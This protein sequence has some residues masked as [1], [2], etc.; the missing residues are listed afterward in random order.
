M[1]FIETWLP[2]YQKVVNTA[3][4][5]FFDTRYGP[6][7][8]I[9]STF[10]EALRYA[11]EWGGKRLRPILTL[12][13][14]EHF[15]QGKGKSIDEQAIL[16]SIGVECVHCFTLVHDDLPCMDNDELRRGKPTVWKAHGETM[17]VLVG[18]T[19][20]TMGFELL[21]RTGN[22]MVVGEIARALGDLG[23]ARGQIRDT[24]L[25]HD[26]LTLD[27]LLRL[28]DEKTG[29]F[30]ASCLVIGAQLGGANE[31]ETDT[32]RKFGFLLGRAFQIQDDILDYEGDASMVGKKVGKDAEIG[33][34]MV[35]LIR[36]DATKKILWDLEQEMLFIA[37][38]FNNAKFRDIVQYVVR[39]EK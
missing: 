22:A 14:Y 25:R 31:T 6:S 19:L 21:S 1:S 8:G 12:L 3:I 30:I 23:V 2:E 10:E 38:T 28:H 18:D 29:W 5:N 15:V 36:I 20:Q 34:G 13:A 33:K 39:R 4:E 24:F 37:D 27:E 16:A 26:A 35:S 11:V 9:E 17:A 7:S 32:M